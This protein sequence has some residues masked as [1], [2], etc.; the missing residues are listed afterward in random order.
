M[1]KRVEVNCFSYDGFF[2]SRSPLSLVVIFFT[3]EALG[4]SYMGGLWVEGHGWKM[5]YELG[6]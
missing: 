1:Y 3:W 6:Y 5:T 4:V 2:F